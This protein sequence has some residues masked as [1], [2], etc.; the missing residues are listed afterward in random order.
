MYCNQKYSGVVKGFL[1]G[2][3]LVFSVMFLG[4]NSNK[5]QSTKNAVSFEES[6]SR[7]KSD[8]IKEVRIKNETAEFFKDGQLAF[9]TSVDS[10]FMKEALLGQISSN[11]I[12][13]SFA[14]E[15]SNPLGYLIQIL[16]WLFFI[17]PPIIVVLLLVIIKKMDASSSNR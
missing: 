14:P 3:V 15:S 2:A 7:I 8:D 13:V 10:D 9:S 1:L 16:F 12:S 5:Y 4:S 11:R 6:L 17:S